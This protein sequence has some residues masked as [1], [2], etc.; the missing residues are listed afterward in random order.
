MQLMIQGSEAAMLNQGLSSM[1]FAKPLFD[2]QQLV[3]DERE[4]SGHEA[5]AR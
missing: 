3:H 5:S 2:C 1:E 4:A